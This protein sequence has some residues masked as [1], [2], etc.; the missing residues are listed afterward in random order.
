MSQL[1][2]TLR[3]VA[4][5]CHQIGWVR[6]SS[7]PAAISQIVVILKL[8][9]RKSAWL[10]R[11][12]KKRPCYWTKNQSEIVFSTAVIVIQTVTLHLKDKPVGRSCPNVTTI[13]LKESPW[14][15]VVCSI[16]VIMKKRSNKSLAINLVHFNGKNKKCLLKW[17]FLFVCYNRQEV[18]KCI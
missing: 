13:W 1:V 8:L 15:Q 7:A 2:S 5:R 18:V 9:S 17:T 3:F 4:V 10:A 14:K 12:A 6:R 16:M 11:S